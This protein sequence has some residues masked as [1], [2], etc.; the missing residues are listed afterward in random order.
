[1]IK[2]TLKSLFVEA[3]YKLPHSVHIQVR[4]K[5]FNYELTPA[6]PDRSGWMWGTEASLPRSKSTRCSRFPEKDS[7]QNILHLL[8]HCVLA[9]G[10]VAP[11]KAISCCL[12]QVSAAKSQSLSKKLIR[13]FDQGA[14]RFPSKYLQRRAILN[15]LT[16][17]FQVHSKPTGSISLCMF[18]ASKGTSRKQ[19]ISNGQARATGQ[20]FV[21]V[22]GFGV[23]DKTS[24][25]YECFALRLFLWFHLIQVQKWTKLV[26]YIRPRG[27]SGYWFIKKASRR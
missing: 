14:L 2:I 8:S 15:L 16:S 23:S 22:F 12:I 5:G 3:F 13:D 1:M 21:L 25:W 26:H 7:F 27:G 6:F 18:L 9:P 4:L 20:D 11:I 19:A 24:P 17:L 10:Q